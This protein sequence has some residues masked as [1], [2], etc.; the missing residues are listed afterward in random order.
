MF[1]REYKSKSLTPLEELNVVHHFSCQSFRFQ[2]SYEEKWQSSR[3]FGQNPENNMPHLFHSEMCDNNS[4]VVQFHVASQIITTLTQ[5]QNCGIQRFE[6]NENEQTQ[7]KK[8]KRTKTNHI[9]ACSVADQWTYQ[10][11]GGQTSRIK[12]G[13]ILEITKSGNWVN[14]HEADLDFEFFRFIYICSSC[15]KIA[16]FEPLNGF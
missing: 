15:Y 13:I 14:K 9:P 6:A 5:S 8:K 4:A 2:W 1:K 12:V 16:Q 11:T 7:K 10:V 3:T